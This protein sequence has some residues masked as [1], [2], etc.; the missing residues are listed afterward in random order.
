MK[1]LFWE[2]KAVEI[3]EI[4][5]PPGR[6]HL[7]MGDPRL[8]SALCWLSGAALGDPGPSFL[9]VPVLHGPKSDLVG[10]VHSFPKMKSELKSLLV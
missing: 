9:T 6:D 5:Q 10:V 7:G 4:N 3:N 8:G 1:S 2:H